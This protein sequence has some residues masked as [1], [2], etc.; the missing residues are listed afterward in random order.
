MSAEVCELQ[1]AKSTNKVVLS[2]SPDTK[3]IAG[4][5]T[6]NDTRSEQSQCE[7]ERR[8]NLCIVIRAHPS[9][10]LWELPG[11]IRHPF[12][13]HATNQ[14]IRTGSDQINPCTCDPILSH[15]PQ[16]TDYI[17]GVSAVAPLCGEFTALR[18]FRSLFPSIDCFTD[19]CR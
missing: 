18:Y 5:A 14:R 6:V 19:A 17:I 9:D 4:K 1:V 10:S 8:A 3:K 7:M 16:S 11:R 13:L 12:G 15:Q 2:K